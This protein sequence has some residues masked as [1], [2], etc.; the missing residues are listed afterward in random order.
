LKSSI[1]ERDSIIQR[2][3]SEQL[4]GERNHAT[5]A[6]ILATIEAQVEELNKDILTKDQT[7][8]ELIERISSLQSN[9]TSL[10][11]RLKERIDEF[12]NEI[13]TLVM[14]NETLEGIFSYDR[15]PLKFLL[16][17]SVSSV[18]IPFVEFFVM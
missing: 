2:L 18:E 15:I 16:L 7:I 8:H 13:N 12:T 11:I 14:K 9:V 10:E 6:A 5:R 1:E 4:T 3:R 17:S